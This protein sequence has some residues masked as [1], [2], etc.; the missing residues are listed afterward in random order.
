MD[1]LVEALQSIVRA[2]RGRAGELVQARDWLLQAQRLETGAQTQA[3]EVDGRLRRLVGDG[4]PGVQGLSTVLLDVEALSELMADIEG[5]TEIGQ[6]TARMATAT[7]YARA[8]SDSG[9]PEASWAFTG[10][11]VSVV[12]SN[13]DTPGGGRGGG[14]GRSGNLSV[15]LAL[16]IPLYSPGLAPASDA[17]RRRVDAAR[18]RREAAL[19]A[20]RYRVVEV[21]EQTLAS[22]ERARRVGAVLRNSAQLR[23]PTLQQWQQLGRRSLAEAMG[24][25]AEHC[26]LRVAYVDALND[27][28]Q[29]NAML[30]SLGRGVQPWLH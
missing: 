1:C 27:G 7:A 22:F 19:E 13:P 16:N 2:D 11:G 29:L 10:A 21:H 15:G 20:R 28:Q 30:Q 17:A 4:L 8:Q 3:R 26:R 24:A 23:S 6:T 12:G 9:K 5:S 18:Q 14:L 25:E